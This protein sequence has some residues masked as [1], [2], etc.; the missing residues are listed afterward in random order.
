VDEQQW[1]TV[2]LFSGREGESFEASGDGLP[3]Q[4]LVLAEVATS[5]TAGGRGPNGEEREQF[6]LLFR[7]PVEPALPQAIYRL[8][9]AELGSLDLFLVPLA[10]RG[11]GAVYEAAFA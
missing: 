6:S 7:G 2:D 3:P 8:D 9:H 11:D 10:P 1:L 4:E 5:G